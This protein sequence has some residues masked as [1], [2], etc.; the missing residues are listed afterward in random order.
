MVSQV[1]RDVL[2]P[3][4]P[5]TC[6]SGRAYGGHGSEPP[7]IIQ[8]T[9]RNRRA[10]VSSNS[11][12]HQ[13]WH[14]NIKI[15]RPVGPYRD[16]PFQW[17]KHRFGGSE[18]LISTPLGSKK[19]CILHDNDRWEP[20]SPYPIWCK[21]RNYISS[22]DFWSVRLTFPLLKDSV[23][24]VNSMQEIQSHEGFEW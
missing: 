1:L 18:M 17:C 19:K 12:N 22:M 2:M 14:Q 9:E 3:A 21:L 6:G 8:Q 24:W 20:M 15:L 7:R 10:S 11:H 5:Y 16:P 4:F 13:M 23:K